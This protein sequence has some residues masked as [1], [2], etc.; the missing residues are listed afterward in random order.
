[1]SK[2]GTELSDLSSC[3]PQCDNRYS[4]EMVEDEL[5]MKCMV[6]KEILKFVGIAGCVRNS[7]GSRQ[8]YAF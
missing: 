1:M 7:S 5:K 3:N 8:G 2:L 4:L 6:G